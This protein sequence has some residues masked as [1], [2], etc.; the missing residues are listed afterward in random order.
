ME[1]F[2]YSSKLWREHHIPGDATYSG[3]GDVLSMS[4]FH[5]PQA[6]CKVLDNVGIPRGWNIKK[7]SW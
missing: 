6:E 2:L 7:K 4:L 5:D 1:P 3:H